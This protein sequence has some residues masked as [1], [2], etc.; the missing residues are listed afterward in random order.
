MLLRWTALHLRRAA[1]APGVALKLLHRNL[2]HDRVYRRRM[3]V[4]RPDWFQAPPTFALAGTESVSMRSTHF[5]H[6]LFLK[7]IYLLFLLLVRKLLDQEC[8]AP[9]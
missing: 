4:I 1:L 5:L 2:L 3:V 7:A 6:F 9:R 8:G